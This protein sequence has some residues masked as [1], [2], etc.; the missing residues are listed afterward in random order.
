M[1][2]IAVS[3]A[4][5]HALEFLSIE[6]EFNGG[7][8]FR[9]EPTIKMS[10]PPFAMVSAHAPGVERWP[11]SHLRNLRKLCSCEGAFM[12][13]KEKYIGVFVEHGAPPPLL[14]ALLAINFIEE[15]V[16]SSRKEDP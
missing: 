14:S 7:R 8:S 9:T 16:S 13:M 11:L 15:G 4:S 6:V 5:H 3:S 12:I 10:G 2:D 1:Y